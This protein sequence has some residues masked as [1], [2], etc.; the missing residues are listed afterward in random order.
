MDRST[1]DQFKKEALSNLA[2]QRAYDELE[3]EFE[4][5]AELVKARKRRGKTQKDVAQSMR[6][7]SSVISRLESGSLENKHSPSIETLRRYAHAL[8]CKLQIKL[9]PEERT[10]K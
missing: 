4:L 7:S 9:V 1:H 10:G 6:T 8:G 5:I 3:E 2:V